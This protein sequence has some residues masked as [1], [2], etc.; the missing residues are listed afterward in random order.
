VFTARHA[1]LRCSHEVR[2][3]NLRGGAARTEEGRCAVVKES[4]NLRRRKVA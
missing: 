4:M 3:Q 2:N 1:R